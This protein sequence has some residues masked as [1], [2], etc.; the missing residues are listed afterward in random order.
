MKASLDLPLL[1]LVPKLHLGT[2]LCL[3]SL[4]YRNAG[5]QVQ[6]R[7]KRSFEDNLRSQVQLGNEG[8]A[9]RH[10]AISGS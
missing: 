9:G 3:G 7:A 5:A 8:G 1:F 4:A 6:Q 10:P 2:Q